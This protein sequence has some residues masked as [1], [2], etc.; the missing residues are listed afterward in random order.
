MKTLKETNKKD[1]YEIE[2]GGQFC[3][4]FNCT[5]R[6]FLAP[7]TEVQRL[8]AFRKIPAVSKIAVICALATTFSIA[9]LW[10]LVKGQDLETLCTVHVDIDI[11][12]NIVQM[13]S[14]SFLD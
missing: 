14:L 6:H 3:E 4:T 8:H 7:C 13:V 9:K 5:Y 10:Y 12:S 11:S 1:R 2:N